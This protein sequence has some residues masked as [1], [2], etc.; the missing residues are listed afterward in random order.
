MPMV[1]GRFV[2]FM[3]QMR[4]TTNSSPPYTFHTHSLKDS[5]N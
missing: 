5:I 3:T 2:S 1:A 4:G